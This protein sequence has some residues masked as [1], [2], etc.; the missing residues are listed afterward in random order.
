MTTEYLK[1]VH[2]ADSGERL[3]KS[4][5]SSQ[6]KFSLCCMDGKIELP[7]LS[8]PPDEL[9]QLH[10]RGDQRIPMKL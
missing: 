6:P 1:R 4:K 7:L 3:A 8:V 9:I 5:Q 10:T 2:S